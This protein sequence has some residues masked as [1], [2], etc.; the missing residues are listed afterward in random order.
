MNE[1]AKILEMLNEGKIT[2]DEAEKLLNAVNEV[3][4]N[5]FQA[6]KP[7]KA[8]AS[9]SSSKTK[10]KIKIEV[11]SSDGDN[12]RISVPLKLVKAIDKMLPNKVALE[13]EEEGINLRDL[14]SN[15][16]ETIDEIDE[17]LVNIVSSEGDNVRIYIE[18]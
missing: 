16:D 5:E 1:K 7:P 8:P 2:V 15:I 3:K 17:D 10:G 6:P 13:L 4:S 12:V 14:I 18:K 11:L 9:P